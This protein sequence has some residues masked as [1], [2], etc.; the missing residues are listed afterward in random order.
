MWGLI[1]LRTILQELCTIF[2]YTVN[3]V[4][5]HSTMFEDNNGCVDLIAAPTMRPRSRHIFIKD[6][7]FREHVRKG[8]IK[9]KWIV[10]DLFT[11]PLT[12]PKFVILQKQILGW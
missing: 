4:L 10:A 1:P 9:I 2:G 11:K 3:Q 7:H 8:H 6:H 12:A 5:T